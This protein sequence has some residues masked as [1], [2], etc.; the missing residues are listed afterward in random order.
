[1]DNVDPKGTGL[2]NLSIKR[3]QLSKGDHPPKKPKVPLEPVVGLMAEGVKTI[4]LVK[5]RTG[6]GFMKA[7]STNQ[8]KPPILFCE[9]TKHALE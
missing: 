6:K 3:K 9:D 7:P 2:S 8:E 4:T 1:M 5:H